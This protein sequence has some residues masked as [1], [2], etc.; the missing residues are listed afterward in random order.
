MFYF[1]EYFCVLNCLLI[2]INDLKEK[3]TKLTNIVNQ[4]NYLVLGF[5]KWLV[6]I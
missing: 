4:L 2:L 3:N 1:E 6:L 5:G